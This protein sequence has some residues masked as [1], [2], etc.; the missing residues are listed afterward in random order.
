MNYDKL[1]QYIN[2]PDSTAPFRLWDEVGYIVPWQDIKNIVKN[3]SDVNFDTVGTA[4]MVRD[5]RRNP[6]KGTN[7]DYVEGEHG[8]VTFKETV[9]FPALTNSVENATIANA[10]ANC[11][12]FVLILKNYDYQADGQGKYQVFGIDGGLKLEGEPFDP[13]ADAAWNITLTSERV[14]QSAVYLWD[15]DEATTDAKWS[16]ITQYEY[17]TG[18]SI[19]SGTVTPQVVFLQVDPD[20][21]CYVV[22]PNG[23]VLTSTA[24]VINDTWAGAAGAVTLIVPKISE[25]IYIEGSDFVGILN[26]TFIG[27]ITTAESSNIEGIIAKN[28]LSLNAELCTSLA[29]ISAPNATNINASGCALTAVAIAAIVRA[30]ILNIADLSTVRFDFSVGTNASYATL[31]AQAQSDIQAIITAGGTVTYNA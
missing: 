26:T 6:F 9:V 17:I 16:L 30:T 23:T 15:T 29:S 19:A 25:S 12:R 13:Y 24:S 4:F 1:I 28:T 7:I 5:R 18:L 10:L 3:G 20:K 31:S 27:N 2:P 14:A 21:T 8:S 22:L 11:G